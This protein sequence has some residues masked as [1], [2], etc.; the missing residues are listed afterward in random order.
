M[1]TLVSKTAIREAIKTQ[2][3]QNLYKF[4][5]LLNMNVSDLIRSSKAARKFKSEALY[6]VGCTNAFKRF[7][8]DLAAPVDMKTRNAAIRREIFEYLREELKKPVSP[9]TK[10]A[11]LGRT[12]LYFCSPVYKFED[13][14]MWCTGLP[15]EG[16]EEFC[17]KVIS[18]SKRYYNEEVQH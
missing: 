6:A 13:Y 8:R 11:M 9:Y 18:I 4:A 10:V 7:E 2:N 14:N 5:H 17:D 15:Y 1:K 12:R 16:N 3:V